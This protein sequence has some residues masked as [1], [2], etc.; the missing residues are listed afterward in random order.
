MNDVATISGT[1]AGCVIAC[2]SAIKMVYSLM[3]VFFR[4]EICRFDRKI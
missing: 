2:N 1:R 4:I 3:V